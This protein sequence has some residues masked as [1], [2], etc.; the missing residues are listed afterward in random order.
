MRLR[1]IEPVLRRALRGPCAVPRGGRIL[2]AVSGGADSTALLVG[3]HALARE[4]GYDL[5]AAHLHHGLRGAEADGDLAFVRELCDR[6]EVPLVSA[7]WDTHARMR[8][9]GLS[10]QAGLRRLRREFL[11]AAARRVQADAIATGHTA[12]D[13]LET[14]LLRLLRGT[15]L[16]GLGAMS[17]RRGEW[18]R[19]LLGA[20]RHA[21]EADLRAAGLAWRE[22][23]SNADPRYARSRVRHD[24]IPALVRALGA[25]P[26]GGQASSAARAV[27]PEAAAA[28]GAL[29]LRVARGLREVRSVG[30]LTERLAGRL[31]KKAIRLDGGAD[32]A[33]ATLALD[34]GAMDRCPGALQRATLGLAWRRLGTGLGLTQRH[35]DAL[36]ELVASPHGGGRCDLP[37]GWVARRDRNVIRIQPRDTGIQA[38]QPPAHRRLRVPGVGSFA[39]H[40]VRG[41]WLPGAEARRRLGRRAMGD[42][43][44]AAGAVHGGLQLRAARSDEW[45]VP[46]GHRR[47]RHLGEFLRK[48]RISAA[49][50]NRPVVIA[51]RRGILSVLGVRRS[52][53]GPLTSGTRKALWIHTETR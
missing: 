21:I 42:E 7:R 20:S 52:A 1:R 23:R 29:A 3:L 6:L 30:R 44:F 37:A 27:Q 50:I 12:D 40:R 10:G 19:P 9:R 53:R 31:A 47:P 49:V 39:G 18:I 14:L 8:R 16:R 25:P 28:R 17:A 22:D 15:G 13:Q 2:A 43:F 33:R 48:Q 36:Q 46:F 45:F 35:L 4:L 38:V 24:V 34:R 51:D 32:R 26:E 41:A 5:V 11:A